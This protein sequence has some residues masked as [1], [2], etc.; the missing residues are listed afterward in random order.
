MKISTPHY[1]QSSNL[2]ENIFLTGLNRNLND[3]F[4]CAA[5]SV[6]KISHLCPICFGKH[7]KFSV[8]FTFLTRKFFNSPPPSSPF[9]LKLSTAPLM[10]TFWKSPNLWVNKCNFS[11]FCFIILRKKK[12]TELSVIHKRPNF[13]ISLRRS[14]EKDLRNHLAIKKSD[15]IVQ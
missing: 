10:S 3:W 15:D 7:S 12:K 5:G 8:V 6:K 13:S 2:L 9:S 14:K 11:Y 4:L 1:L